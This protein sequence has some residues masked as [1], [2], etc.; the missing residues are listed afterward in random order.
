MNQK[1]KKHI[2]ILSMDPKKAVIRFSVPMIIAMLADA[3]Y[4]FVNAVWISGRGTTSLSAIGLFFPFLTFIM[5][6][7]TG[8]G[9]GGAAVVSQAIGSE[10]R[11][12][13]ENALL[14]SIILSI[15]ISVLLTAI[16]QIIIRPLLVVMGAAAALEEALIYSRLMFAG[17]VFFVL[18][19]NLFALLRSI[20][21]VRQSM[22]IS[23]LGTILNMILDPFLIYSFHMGHFDI[24]FH[25]GV[26]GAA[27]ATLISYL[28][29]CVILLILFRRNTDSFSLRIKN[30]HYDKKIIRKILSIGIPA[31]VSQISLA[32]MIA[33]LTVF[34]AKIN[35]DE[36][37]AI[38][39]AGWRVL[40]VAVLPALGIALGIVPL[41]GTYFGAK[42]MDKFKKASIYALWLGFILESILA[43][44]VFFF[45][46]SISLSFSWSGNSKGLSRDIADFLKVLCL[47]FPGCSIG[48]IVAGILQGAGKA[49]YALGI[50]LLRTIILVI[51]LSYVF[52]LRMHLGL[53]GI[54]L[55]LLCGSWLSGIAALIIARHLIRKE[56]SLNY[57]HI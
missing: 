9:I 5:A 36:S 20:G 14:H 42:D 55:G 25:L 28:F 49:L 39:T 29:N 40:L 19:S 51:P 33:V 44:L 52:S 16:F 24:G 26:S 1:V 21:K 32:I 2:S 4:N 30:F 34:V 23:I 31:S 38:F 37:I 35:G 3:S 54:N 43:L 46:P 48:Y 53:T 12:Q 18:S 17:L 15:I 13:A 27:F 22:I 8:L 10:D 56:E 7:S 11:E 6:I 47:F 45:A 50:T 41:F 57:Y